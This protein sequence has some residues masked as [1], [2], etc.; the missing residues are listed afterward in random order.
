[1][2]FGAEVRDEV[3]HLDV[4]E[5][6]GTALLC[7]A[8]RS[9]GS[10]HLTGRG[11]IHGEFEVGG[12]AVARALVQAIRAHGADCEIRQYREERLARRT[13][14]RLVVNADAT[15]HA[16]LR[17]IGVLDAEGRPQVS[18]D[19]AMAWRGAC[20]RAYLRGACMVAVSVAA[21]ERPAHLEIRGRDREAVEEIARL[22][23]LE[24]V[25]LQIRERARW[26]E[27][28]A[29]RREAVVGLLLA[30]GA[31]E[32]ALRC[33]EAEV[34]LV[35]R[36]TA[37]RR[38]NFDAANLRKQVAATRRQLAAVATLR[39]SGALTALPAPL[40]E[41]AALRSAQPDLT[42]A[43]L[44]ALGGVARPTLAA[45]LRRLV[46]LAEGEQAPARRSSL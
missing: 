11:R 22:A 7:G 9:C 19:R 40:R 25:A 12:H 26:W 43:E 6:C 46:E 36:E 27:A 33:E 24:G 45:R 4:P 34:L 41:A 2:S 10:L 21:P 42:L 32:A 31:E 23:L 14:F 39:A 28:Y 16:L 5:P 20:R 18:P 29:R 30:I 37:N 13:R 1:M 3:A 44:A 17:E 8:F 35:T 15:G 38:A